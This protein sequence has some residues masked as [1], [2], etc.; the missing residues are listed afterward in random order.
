MTDDTA[1][2]GPQY[3]GETYVPE[4]DFKRL[5]AQRLRVFELMKDGLPRT[6]DQISEK[7]GDPAPSVSARLRDFRKLKFGAHIVD[8]EYLGNGLYTYQ[9]YVND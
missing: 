6:L 8:R 9:L 5:D 4:R 7:T 1:M 3:D 2:P